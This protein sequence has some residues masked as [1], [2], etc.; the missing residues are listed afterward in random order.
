ME[1]PRT[2]RGLFLLS[3]PFVLAASSVILLMDGE[4][5]ADFVNIVVPIISALV[6]ALAFLLFWFNRKTPFKN[7][8]LVIL[9]TFAQFALGWTAW[10]IYTEYVGEV[11]SIIISDVLWLTGYVMM[12]LIFA[13]VIRK[14]EIDFSNR[15]LLV[16]AIYWMAMIAILWWAIAPTISPS[17]PLLW[18]NVTYSLY[19]IFD[20]ILLSELIFLSWIHRKG[21]LE[22]VWLFISTAVVFWTVGDVIYLIEEASGNYFVGSLPDVFYLCNYSLLAI[23]FGLLVSTR[24]KYT[25]IVPVAE[26]ATHRVE[27]TTLAPMKTYVVYGADSKAAYDLMVK[28]LDMGLEGLIVTRRSPNSI[29]SAYGLKKTAIMWLSTTP[30][31]EVVHPSSLGI[32]TDAVVRFLERSTNAIVL[33]DGF[34]SLITYNDFRRA[35]QAV[36][37]IKDTTL[38]HNSRLVLAV[39]K[40]T[41]DPKEVALLEKN[42][43]IVPG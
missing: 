39:D 41:L 3:A 20:S 9:V 16:L 2:N 26:K 23:G 13:Q 28:N 40:R 12:I 10:T 18:H 15:M 34:E 29:R 37:L 33:L 11:S 38:T 27:G 36:E 8:G 25:S 19:P 32:L 14:T 24:V 35:L 17:N 5:A 42:S 22:D 31:L 1:L 30:G 7:L 6:A 4:T 21:Q 43:V